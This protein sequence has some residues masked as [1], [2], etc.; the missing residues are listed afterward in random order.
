MNSVIE[1]EC[2]NCYNTTSVSYDPE[3]TPIPGFCPVCAEPAKDELEP[4]DFS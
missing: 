4:L 2:S 3:E 1:M